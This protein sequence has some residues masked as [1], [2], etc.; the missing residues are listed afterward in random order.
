VAEKIEQCSYP[1]L[2]NAPALTNAVSMAPG[3][4]AEHS[5]GSVDDRLVDASQKAAWPSVLWPALLDRKNKTR[6]G[7]ILPSAE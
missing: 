2:L 1:N 6:S 3:G 7:T 5:R 4:A